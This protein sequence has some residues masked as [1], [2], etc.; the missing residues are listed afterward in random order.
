MRH[1]EPHTESDRR[2]AERVW[3]ARLPTER[4]MYERSK[5]TVE[6]C[7]V[8]LSTFQQPWPNLECVADGCP[9]TSFT[10]NIPWD[11]DTLRLH[12]K[13]ACRE[14]IRPCRLATVTWPR[15]YLAKLLCVV[16]YTQLCIYGS[17][18][19]LAIRCSYHLF[20]FT[21]CDHFH[22]IIL[23]SLDVFHLLGL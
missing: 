4:Y 10:I 11:K 20:I 23:Y 22:C 15:M 3:L 5:G 19:L 7:R 17:D 18:I 16:A 14:C 1:A 2:C 12:R 8:R 9:H 21:W 6:R 13:Q